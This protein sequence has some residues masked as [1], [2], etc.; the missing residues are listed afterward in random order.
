MSMTNLPRTC[1]GINVHV[2]LDFRSNS[3]TISA[4]IMTMAKSISMT[5]IT[6]TIIT[7]G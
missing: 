3:M 2:N 7:C 4:M 5:I 1:I 6:S